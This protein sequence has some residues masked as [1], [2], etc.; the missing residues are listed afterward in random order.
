METRGVPKNHGPNLAFEELPGT[1]E[2][3]RL[4]R[5]YPEDPLG[6]SDHSASQVAQLVRPSG[7][8][9]VPRDRSTDDHSQDS[10]Q[11]SDVL[12]VLQDAA[13]FGPG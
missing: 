12:E 11:V 1:V 5:I 6:H 4:V 2:L 8:G 7:D 9:E 3:P 13:L 10:V